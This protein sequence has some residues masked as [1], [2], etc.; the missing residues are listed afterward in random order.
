MT[1]ERIQGTDGIRGSVCRLEDSVSMDPISALLNEG[2][3]T[4]EF[5]ELYTYAFCQEL[6]ESG[7]A[8]AFD[9]AVIGWDPRDKSEIGRAHV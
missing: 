7:I 1:I 3:L 4:E 5:F 9:L 6:L 2:V 8:S